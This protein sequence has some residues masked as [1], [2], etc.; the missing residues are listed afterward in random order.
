[1]NTSILTHKQTQERSSYIQVNSL[2]ACLDKV[3]YYRNLFLHSYI[4]LLL[5]TLDSSIMRTEENSK[6]KQ[7]GDYSLPR[8]QWLRAQ[9]LESDLVWELSDT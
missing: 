3:S 5:N 4:K 1:M 7:E 2:T 8:A 9:A 6:Y